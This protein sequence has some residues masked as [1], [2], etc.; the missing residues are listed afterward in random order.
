MIYIVC[1]CGI[2]YTEPQ[3][4]PIKCFCGL[5]I[6]IDESKELRKNIDIRPP[7]VVKF[8]DNQSWGNA[9]WEILHTKIHTNKE[10]KRW[11]S[12]LPCGSCRNDFDKLLKDNPP[13]F[14]SQ[15]NF[16][17]WTVL[18]HNKV[19]EKLNKPIVTLEQ[20]RERWCIINKANLKIIGT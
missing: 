14:S 16:F 19:N 11:L 20:A 4:W 10:F 18:I 9:A 5:N 17:E 3:V 2:K 13:D 12:F 8:N 6:N 15:T 1:D 7:T